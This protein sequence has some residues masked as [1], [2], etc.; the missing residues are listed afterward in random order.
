MDLNTLKKIGFSDKAVTVYLSL[1]KLGPSSVRVLAESCS[2]NRGTTYDSLKWLEEQKLVSF[3]QKESRQHFVAEPPSK[4]L[5]LLRE[6]EADLS[7][8]GREL[9]RAVPE[10]EALYNRG[11]NRPVARYFSAA[12][13][14]EIL[15]DVLSTCEANGETGY[16]IYSAERLRDH[17]YRDFSTFSDV[18]L[19]KGVGVKVIALGEGGELRGLDERKWLPHSDNL[20]T[21]IIIYPGKTAYISLNAQ[22]DPVGVVIEN[23]GVCAT[24]TRIFD[25]LWN[26][27]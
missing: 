13:L 18:R 26:R 1:L 11:G 4:L 15:E 24:Q 2:L 16:R 20:D 7:Q 17:L 6:R 10:L 19:A 12:E 21:Y 3:Y 14:P 9:H 25:E 27:L 5:A 8:A 22:N 23:E